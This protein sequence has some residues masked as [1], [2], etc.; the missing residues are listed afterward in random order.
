MQLEIDIKDVSEFTKIAGKVEKMLNSDDFKSYIARKALNEVYKI[1]SESLTTDIDQSDPN[2]NLHY[3]NSHETSIEKDG[4]LI[5][6]YSMVDL[7]SS[8]KNP[9][10]IENYPDGLSLAKLVEYGTGIV[11]ASSEGSKYAGESD[12]KYDV[13]GHGVRGWWYVEGNKIHWTQGMEGK[14]IYHKLEQSV[15]E[16]FAKWT[17]DYLKRNLGGK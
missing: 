4:V 11:G 5:Y 1:T 8:D 16:K 9:E 6:N 12:W 10:L 2:A 14:L 17:F 15:R 3:R 7:E 13:N